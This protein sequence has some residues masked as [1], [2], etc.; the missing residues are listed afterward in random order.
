VTADAERLRRLLGTDDL[1]W[2]VERVRSQLAEGR[3]LTGGVTLS[4]ASEAQRQAVAR[5][6]GR[7]VGRGTSLSVSLPALAAVLARGGLAH[8]L[9][10]AVTALTG[11]V[12]NQPAAR[13][14]EAAA[15]AVAF[16]PVAGAVRARPAL[17]EWADRLRTTG[18]L[19]RL[20]PGDPG[21]ARRLAQQAV[22]VLD[23]LPLDGVPLSVLAT[24]AAGDG[25]ALDHDRPLSTLV[26][27]AAAA[28]GGVPDGDGAEWRHTVWS[29]VGVLSQELTGPVLT[30]NL[31]GDTATVTGRAL[32]LWREAGQP[33]HL[34]VRQL[35]RHPPE[36]R[37][38]G[39]AVFIC[40]NPTVVS[41]AANRLG[42]TA[43]PL[44]CASGHP[45]GAATLLL[46]RLAE[47]G[48]ALRYHGDFDW[49]GVTIAR[50][51]ISRFGATPW[52]FD[53]VAYRSAVTGGRGGEPLRGAP[54]D[55]SWDAGLT[56]AMIGLGVRVEEEA[57]ID[58]LLS[59]LA[60]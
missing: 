11:P 30:L 10:A 40:E 22:A 3:P 27:H 26:L 39:R 53:A 50:G 52:R 56:E 45:A 15:W 58:D 33:V 18:L 48:A 5:L 24:T 55:A 7:P 14:V 16:T 41:E 17:A 13:A 1:R 38:G 51:V 46:R 59:D 32:A 29:S 60:R 54:V 35:L 8:D 2:L 36:L 43:A 25:H 12:P 44:V 49:P 19:R 37:L 23:R 42:P 47:S 9:A 31:P 57:V 21:R 4:D 20:A 28:L 34:T 6:L